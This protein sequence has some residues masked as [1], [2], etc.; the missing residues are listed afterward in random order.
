MDCMTIETLTREQLLYEFDCV[1]ISMKS[2]QIAE[3]VRS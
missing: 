2:S 3:L 1:G